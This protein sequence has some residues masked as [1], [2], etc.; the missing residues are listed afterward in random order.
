MAEVRDRGTPWAEWP[1]F[2]SPASPGRPKD[3]AMAI[4]AAQFALMSKLA[5]ARVLKDSQ[6]GQT[7]NLNVGTQEA[8]GMVRGY[9]STK[10]RFEF[11]GAVYH[12]LNRCLER[13][14]S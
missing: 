4:G 5:L 6:L 2:P 13:L 9:E 1:H 14:P 3:I 10:S 7:L 11:P 8:T 12:I